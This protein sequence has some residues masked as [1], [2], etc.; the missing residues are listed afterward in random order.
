MSNFPSS[1]AR[2]GKNQCL[3][4]YRLTAQLTDISKKKKFFFLTRR[5][6]CNTQSIL[7]RSRIKLRTKIYLSQISASKAKVR[8]KNNKMILDLNKKSINHFGNFF[9]LHM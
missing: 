3:Q 7:C 8:I 9:M 4:H 6:L 2:R 1:L 5:K